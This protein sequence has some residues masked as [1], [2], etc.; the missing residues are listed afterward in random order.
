MLI[1]FLRTNF[2]RN[3]MTLYPLFIEQM[4]VVPTMFQTLMGVGHC[5]EKTRSIAMLVKESLGKPLRT[6]LVLPQRPMEDK[7]PKNKCICKYN[8]TNLD[9]AMR[10]IMKSF[11]FI[12]GCV[13]MSNF[14]RLE[15]CLSVNRRKRKNVFRQNSALGQGPKT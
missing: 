10:R 13:R 7:Y 2:M 4:H 11:R 8:I 9:T 14:S 3:A 12:L 1:E 5:H 15:R 6:S